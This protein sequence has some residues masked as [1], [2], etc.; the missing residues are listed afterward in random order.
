MK[1][2]VHAI[3][4]VL[5]ILIFPALLGGLILVISILQNGPS[6]WNQQTI[7]E[8]AGVPASDIK[9]SDIKSLNKSQLM[10]LFFAADAPPI[11]EMV[12]EYRGKIV[13]I[14][15][16]ALP[17][18]YYSR[19]LFGP[20]VWSGKAFY[21]YRLRG[22]GEGYN[23]FTAR[24]RDGQTTVYRTCRVRTYITLSNIDKNKNSFHID[25]KPFNK[26]LNGTLHGEIRKINHRIYLG[27][28]YSSV[29]GGSLNPI[30]FVLHGPATGWVGP[31]E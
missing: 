1:Q 4:R 16:L 18:E 13:R 24:G 23:L 6:I 29:V 28:V 25:Y 12:G 2:I 14:G 3:N 9:L 5:I 20:G 19:Y 30:P 10:Q 7:D 26:G 17:F 8:I 22:D 27:M 15:I 31:S 21:P 11:E